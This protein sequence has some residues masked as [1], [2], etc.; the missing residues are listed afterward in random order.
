[1]HRTEH[2]GAPLELASLPR[3][4]HVELLRV[5]VRV[6]E[7]VLVHDAHAVLTDRTHRELRL[8]R[9]VRLCGRGS[10]RARRNAVSHLVCDRYAA[11]REAERD[12]PVGRQAREPR[13]EPA[14]GIGSVTE[15]HRPAARARSRHVA[16]VVPGAPHPNRRPIRPLG[17]ALPWSVTFRVRGTPPGS[18]AV[19]AHQLW[20]LAVGGSNPPSPTGSDSWRSNSTRRNTPRS[21]F[22]VATFTR[23]SPVGSNAVSPDGIALSPDRKLLPRIGQPGRRRGAADRHRFMTTPAG[24][25][26]RGCRRRAG[27]RLSRDGRRLHESRPVSSSQR[28][29]AGRRGL[30]GR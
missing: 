9:E 11:A 25:D 1:M 19:V 29:L 4:D 20:E 16:I 3:R 22:A 14:P 12:E 30:A 2:S 24:H 15:S 23:R 17:P 21:H 8:R 5:D 10:R 18:G 27:K 28:C 7:H 6:P 13:R 26:D